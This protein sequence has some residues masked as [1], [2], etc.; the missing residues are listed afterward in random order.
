MTC[1]AG[2][3]RCCPGYTQ[4]ILG[5]PMAA[6]HC[7]QTALSPCTWCGVT[8]CL[9]LCHAM[10]LGMCHVEEHGSGAQICHQCRGAS[11]SMIQSDMVVPARRDSEICMHALSSQAGQ[12]ASRA[13]RFANPQKAN[14][15]AQSLARKRHCLCGVSRRRCLAARRA[16]AARLQAIRRCRQ[17]R[18]AARPAHPASAKAARA[19][20]PQPVRQANIMVYRPAPDHKPPTCALYALC[21]R[22]NLQRRVRKHMRVLFFTKIGDLLQAPA[23]P[24]ARNCC[25]KPGVPIPMLFPLHDMHDMT[26]LKPSASGTLR[27]P[28]PHPPHEQRAHRLRPLR[29]VL[30]R[31]RVVVAH[32]RV[33]PDGPAEAAVAAGARHAADLHVRRDALLRA[34][35]RQRHP[36]HAR[37]ALMSGHARQSACSL[38]SH[39]H[40]EHARESACSLRSP[41]YFALQARGPAHSPAAGCRPR[42]E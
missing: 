28:R 18:L 1:D 42:W 4:R 35:H 33:P 20:P 13:Q 10:C 16:A 31:R 40:L 17:R 21:H 26:H 41:R 29:A 24:S 37:A 30:L 9:A 23:A 11:G 14:S 36:G 15:E 7:N 25:S 39:Y 22:L 19:R 34:A 12:I 32:R 6:A 38:H 2:V 3:G 8:A 27:P 5:P